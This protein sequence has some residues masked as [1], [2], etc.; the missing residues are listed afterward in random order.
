MSSC[1]PG[2]RRVAAPPRGMAAGFALE[3]L[4]QV[5]IVSNFVP[6]PEVRVAP[7]VEFL[8]GSIVAVKGVIAG[9]DAI[10][11][12]GKK[13]MAYSAKSMIPYIG[14]LM[15]INAWRKGEAST[16]RLLAY[17]TKARQKKEKESKKWVE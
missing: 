16:I 5:Q 4:L 6:I 14:P 11:A 1:H 7:A 3:K 12:S 9:D 10:I 13:R 17:P 15:D 2:V 8:N